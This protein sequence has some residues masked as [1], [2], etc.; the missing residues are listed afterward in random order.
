MGNSCPS[1][2]IAETNNPS[3]ASTADEDG[4][5]L[6][7]NSTSALFQSLFVIVQPMLRRVISQILMDD[8]G[9]LKDE[10]PM[11]KYN[12]EQPDESLPI[13]PLS[14][15]FQHVCVLDPKSLQQDMEAMPDF[16]WPERDNATV[17]MKQH[18]QGVGGML[19]LD[20]IDFDAKIQFSKG[21][22]TVFPVKGPMGIMGNLEIGSGGDIAD[23]WVQ[24]QVPKLR[25]WFVH[26]K[27]MIFA[28]FLGRPN[29]IPHLH[30]NADFGRDFCNVNVTEDG[31]LDDVVERILSGFGPNNNSNNNN[32]QEENSTNPKQDTS[33][34]GNTL[35]ALI[36]HAMSGLQKLGNGRPIEVS[37][38]E[39]D[40]E[41]VDIA[42]RPV[43]VIKA[44]IE[45]LEKELELSKRAE[46]EK[47]DGPHPQ[48]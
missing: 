43:D 12:H 28:A 15:Q 21:I 30:V 27:Q 8:V 40:Q 24:L 45:R 23:A 39:T 13:Q 48:K 17:L 29:L 25:V 44:D 10:A 33:F 2:T 37:L 14:V 20:L 4:K 34:V 7:N 5:T 42:H 9:L 32:P 26:E 36:V 18:A 35:G 47:G 22:E 19:V 1:S 41:S 31:S 16:E 11:E 6:E 46:M 38:K 3:L